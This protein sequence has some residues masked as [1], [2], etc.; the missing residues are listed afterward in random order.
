MHQK[1]FDSGVLTLFLLVKCYTP[2]DFQA[3]CLLFGNALLKAV[4]G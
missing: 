2:V 3:F 1:V 4:E